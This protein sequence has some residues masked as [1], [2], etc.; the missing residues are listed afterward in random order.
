M[1]T[2]DQLVAALRQADAA[3]DYEA[4]KRF[5]EL[6]KQ[7]Q[8][9]TP[10]Q[11]AQ[12][13]QYRG[14]PQGLDALSPEQVAEVPQKAAG[15]ARA[16]GQG[17]TFGFAD[18]AEAGIV[19]MLSNKTYK[20]ARDEIRELN[21]EFA[22]KNPG[23]AMGAELAGGVATGGAL[24]KGAVKG[25]QAVTAGQK[26]ARGAG[27]GAAEGGAY[28]AG[29]SDGET[30]GEVAQD[31]AIGAGVGGAFGFAAGGVESYL[32]SKAA[33]SEALK[34]AIQ[35]NPNG[36]VVKAMI[37]G[38]Q[39]GEMKSV[40]KEAHKQG[41]DD[42][43]IGTIVGANPA[44]RALMRKMT[45]TYVKNQNNPKNAIRNRPADVVGESVAKRYKFVEGKNREAGT[46][47]DNAAEGLKGETVD[48]MSAVDRFL[49]KM[50]EAGVEMNE[51]GL[52]F[53]GSDFDPFPA[54]QSLIKKV[55]KQASTVRDAHDVHKLKRTIDK[56]VTYGKTNNKSA[57]IDAERLVK[58]FRKEL[59]TLLDG[60]FSDYDS[61]NTL[62]AKTI[63]ALDDVNGLLGK[64][65]SS[66]SGNFDKTLGTLARRISSNAMSGGRVD[67]AFTKLDDVAR[68]VGGQFT[69][70]F[71]TLVVFA[72]E[73]ERRFPTQIRNSLQGQ[74]SNVASQAGQAASE[75]GTFIGNK[76]ANAYQK[77]TGVSDENALI[78]LRR[79]LTQ[80]Q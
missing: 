47:I 59:D 12:R 48:H 79:L 40:M 61:A 60:K 53:N 70:D 32:V 72:N 25:I 52:D 28:G 1:P 74:T 37:K 50:A 46:A 6:I 69:D 58:G 76:L 2:R 75:P 80:K 71:D 14:E 43:V 54:S 38:G 42:G 13:S 26:L 44:D 57:D 73:F 63:D 78:A 55:F 24:A 8:S 66:S 39:N 34:T 33:K 64:S 17:A 51:K 19:S 56:L 3:G 77:A 45:N 62:Y 22:E 30:A 9:V 68:D 15:L 7:E 10:Q 11:P 16:V 18:E 20:Q 41:I 35:N 21:A 31:A 4:A 29:A 67:D 36:K 23:L 27:I 5:A 49:D 65:T